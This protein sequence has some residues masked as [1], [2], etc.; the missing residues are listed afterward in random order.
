[1]LELWWLGQAGFRLHDPSGGPRVYCDPFLTPSTA[2][3]WQAP[4]DPAELAAEA[5]V[6]LVSHQHTDHFDRPMLQAAAAAGHFSLVL[7]SPLVDAALALGLPSNRVIGAQPGVAIETGGVRVEPVAACHGVNV[8]DAYTLGE[9]ISDG[10]VRYLGY[11][12]EVGG[13][14][15]YHSGDCIPYPGQVERL[16]ALKPNV[17]CLP[18]N[19]RDF[20]RESEFNIV[21]NMDFREAARVANDI[22]AQVLVPMHWELF[23]QNRGYPGDLLA[24][25]TEHYPNL[26][27]LVMGRGARI[28]LSTSAS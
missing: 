2:R 4:I 24:Y 26:S 5:D 6:V 8:E 12:V 23:A 1:V 7:P 14:R 27:V 17:A 22:G 25:T 15:V 20:F 28:C 16:S 18:I 10:R 11:V 19:G 13:V 9:E 3:A 21:G